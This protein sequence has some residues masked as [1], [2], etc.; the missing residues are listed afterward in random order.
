MAS[1]SQDIFS[2]EFSAKQPVYSFPL[3]V[4]LEILT[5]YKD[6]Y[7]SFPEIFLNLTLNGIYDDTFPASVSR[8]I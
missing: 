3:S 4:S 1:N 5:F 6:I 8:E 7:E 2:E